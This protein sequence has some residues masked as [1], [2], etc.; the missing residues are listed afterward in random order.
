MILCSG[1]PKI[2]VVVIVSVTITTDSVSKLVQ[3]VNI[4]DCDML[5]W[6]SKDTGG[7]D[8]KYYYDY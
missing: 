3:V 2:L 7:S 5:R 1:T 8:G 4:V 6:H